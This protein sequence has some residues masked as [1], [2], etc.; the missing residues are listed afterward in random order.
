MKPA[1]LDQ[2][3][4]VLRLWDRRDVYAPFAIAGS[5]S[6]IA[7]GVLASA[8]A[9]PMPT[10]HGVWAVA[11]LVLVLGVGQLT[12]GA[13]HA[14]L[15]ATPETPRGA[16]WA[17]TAFNVAG[18]AI[19]AGVVTGYVAVFDVGAVLLFGTL[20]LFLYEVRTAARPGWALNVYRLLIAVLV[21]SIP[22]GTFIT[23]ASG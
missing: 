15:P 12:L 23:T 6:V 1:D 18:L 2:R 4:A 9:A 20:V 13:G 19:L 21:V 10:R 8:I 16:V 7:G 17:A 3:P 22:I 5:V 14:L 11:Y